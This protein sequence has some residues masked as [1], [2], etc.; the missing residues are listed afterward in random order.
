MKI[1]NI[2]KNYLPHNLCD[3]L[4][5]WMVDAVNTKSIGVGPTPSKHRY[6]TRL[7]CGQT[8]KYKF[9]E[10]VGDLYKQI[11]KDY[12]L[13]KWHYPQVQGTD[14]VIAVAIYPGG[15]IYEHT[16]PMTGPHP[17]SL[18]RCAIISSVTEG[19]RVWVEGQPYTLQKGDM[20]QCL[21]SRHKH[22][23][24]TV[25]GG[26]DDVRIIWLFGWYVDGD[27]WE[28]SIQ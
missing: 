10:L 25:V 2:I 17:K 24:E 21:V 14:G 6:T 22:R 3:E 27:E 16:D 5:A 13:E 11:E 28:A 12:N 19:G 4:N 26:P 18:L 15:D 1:V 20:Y 9:P 7:V 23:V 8:P